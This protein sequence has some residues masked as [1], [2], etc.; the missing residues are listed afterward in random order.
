VWKHIKTATF[1]KADQNIS[2]ISKD[3]QKLKAQVKGLTKLVKNIT[4]QPVAPVLYMDTLR[5]K[6]SP[7]AGGKPDDQYVQAIP[8]Y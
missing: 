2:N 7:P 3:I 8:V 5:S 6:G 4:K 1:S